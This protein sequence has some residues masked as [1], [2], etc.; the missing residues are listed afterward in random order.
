[1]VK[2]TKKAKSAKKSTAIAHKKSAVR[3]TKGRSKR[4]KSRTLVAT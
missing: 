4:A 1:M 2:K 3:T